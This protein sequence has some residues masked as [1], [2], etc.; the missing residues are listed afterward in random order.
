[1]ARPADGDATV[2]ELSA[3]Y[4]ISLQAVSKHLKVLG[5]CGLVSR[6]KPTEISADPDVPGARIQRVFDATPEQ[7]VR[8]HTDPDLVVRWL[9]PR[10]LTMTI[11]RWD[12]RTGGE[13]RYVHH[14]GEEEYA[15]HGC[16]H[17][18]GPTR[19]VQTF[20]FEGY[21]EGVSLERHTLT[22]LGEGR[23]RLEVFCIVEGFEARDAMLASGMET[24]VV[25][26][27]EQIDELLLDGAL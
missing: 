21:P 23:T 10:D 7:L 24:G 19:I 22:D 18:V 4:D 25:Q 13:Y 6:T 20:T 5:A 3:P 11:D 15:F 17:E 27:Y 26:G 12:A 2:T 9:G 16:F 14:R 1:M 8:A